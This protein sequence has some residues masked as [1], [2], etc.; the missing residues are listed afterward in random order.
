MILVVRVTPR[1][2]KPGVD[3]WRVGADGRPELEVRVAAPPADGA[4]NH[5]VERLLAGH[6]GLARSAV[7]IVRG[8]WSR[9]KQ[10]EVSGDE[11]SIRASLPPLAGG[12]GLG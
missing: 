7:R 9:T 8:A 12:Q 1:S 2:S 11:A 3:G 4:A 6:L 10:V 5:A